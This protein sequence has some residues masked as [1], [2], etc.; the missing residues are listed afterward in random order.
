MEYIVK[1]KPDFDFNNLSLVQPI[2]VQGGAFFTKMLNNNKSFY[3]QTPSSKTKQG[4]IKSSAKKFHCDLMFDKTNEDL[5]E[6]FEKLEE[7]C[8]S[9]IYDKSNEW[10]EDKI[11][12]ADIESAF[13]SCIRVYKSGKYYLVRCGIKSNNETKEPNIKIYDENESIIEFTNVTNETNIISIIEI[14]GIKFTSKSFQIELVLK[15]ILVLNNE[16][17][18][19]S[20][21]IKK[22]IGSVNKQEN[23]DNDLATNNLD[24]ESNDLEILVDTNKLEDK[25]NFSDSLLENKNLD[26]LEEES[27]IENNEENENIETSN[28]EKNIEESGDLKSNNDDNIFDTSFS[29]E[30]IDSD[31]IKIDEDSNITLK[32]PSDIYLDLYNET[33][34][35]AIEA[36]NEALKAYLEA[37]HIK[38]TY[39]I[40]SN[41]DENIDLEIEE[42]EAL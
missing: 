18:F 4:I 20:C 24:K 10:F 2:S 15:Q 40:D 19:S 36:K 17:T 21:V 35:K 26:D 22:E 7:K 13:T 42:L 12:K 37:K 30:E 32:K 39:L 6:W 8:Q 28:L 38:N 5:V 11:E 31:F 16:P 25:E 14:Q 27:F 41:L 33:L 3:I 34:N 9:L 29:L 1:P 23:I